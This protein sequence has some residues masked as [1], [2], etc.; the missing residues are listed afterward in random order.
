MYKFL[1]IV[2]TLHDVQLF[3]DIEQVKQFVEHGV[4]TLLIGVI[5]WLGHE[6]RHE[7]FDNTK[8]DGHDVH[9]YEYVKQ[10]VHV[11]IHGSQVLVVLL[12]TVKLA[13]HVVEHA[14]LY[15]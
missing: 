11:L 4:H 8:S 6:L 5:Y 3:I 10:V 12:A 9:E 2:V 15:R 7:L 14:L 13:G 1:Y